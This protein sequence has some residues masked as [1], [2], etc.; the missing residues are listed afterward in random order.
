MSNEAVKT[1]APAL[2]KLIDKVFGLR[3]KK[4]ALEAQTKALAG[5]IETIESELMEAMEKA[6]IEKTSTAKGT[7]SI[8]TSTVASVEDWDAFYAYIHKNKFWHLLQ[9]R[10]SDPAYRELLEQGKKVPGATPFHKKRVNFRVA[11]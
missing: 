1:R 6:G 5:E 7:A 3:E 4:A 2:G 11:S 10:V 8:S 9:R